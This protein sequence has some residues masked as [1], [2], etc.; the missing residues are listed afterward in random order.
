MAKKKTHEFVIRVTFDQP[1][2]AKHALAETKDNI[3]GD[4]YCNSWIWERG[5]PQEFKVK[6]FKPKKRSGA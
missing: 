6:S 4:F 5:M 3:H 1:C 2:T